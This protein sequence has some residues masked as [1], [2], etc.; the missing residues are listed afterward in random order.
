MVQIR[1]DFKKFLIGAET[2]LVLHLHDELIYEVHRDHV[3][4]AAALLKNAMENAVV[5]DV[6]IPVKVRSGSSWGQLKLLE[7]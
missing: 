5:L 2:H 6:P 3:L 4:N 1:Q 7:V